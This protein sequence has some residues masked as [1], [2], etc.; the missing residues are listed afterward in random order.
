MIDLKVFAADSMHYY[1]R[2]R[3]KIIPSGVAE[4]GERLNSGNGFSSKPP[5]SLSALECADLEAVAL[6]RILAHYKA[7]SPF[8]PYMLARDRKVVG[9]KS[10][11][12]DIVSLM[13]E[14]AVDCLDWDDCD[15][16]PSVTSD[17][18]EWVRGKTHAV[19]GRIGSDEVWITQGEAIDKYGLNPRSLWWRRENSGIKF[20]RRN[21]SFMYEL[22][23]LLSVTWGTRS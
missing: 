14:D 12:G 4:Y 23:S 21:G 16:V 13:A 5:L 7:S 8:D 6:W 22:G 10:G 17:Y 18:C 15:S 19:V 2:L 9:I 20:E 1:C 11:N 3:E